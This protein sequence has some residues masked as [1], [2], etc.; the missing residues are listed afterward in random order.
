MT[1]NSDTRDDGRKQMATYIAMVARNELENFHHCWLSDKQ[2]LILNTTI[3]NA[4]YAALS[5]GSNNSD[6]SKAFVLFH[7]RM[8][9][10]Y[11]EEPEIPSKKLETEL[12]LR[13]GVCPQ[14]LAFPKKMKT[15]KACDA[16]GWK[17][18]FPSPMD[19]ELTKHAAP[20]PQ[21]RAKIGQSGEVETERP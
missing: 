14:C 5:H 17:P 20:Q 21:T 3:R 15:C 6:Y 16:T 13:A 7:Q 19:P 9:P 8:I 12:W 4:I 2:M 1:N 10:S 11:W 18:G